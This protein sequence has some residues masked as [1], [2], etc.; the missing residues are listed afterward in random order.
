MEQALARQVLFCSAIVIIILLL[1]TTGQALPNADRQASPAQITS[2]PV[3]VGWGGARL[4]EAAL[5]SV[6]QQSNPPPSQVFSGEPA[7]NLE[8]LLSR[9]KNSGYSGVRVSFDPY[10]TDTNDTNYMSVYNETTARRAVEI[11][12]HFG[13]WV[14]FDHHGYSDIF[15]NTSCWL[16]YWK[17][18]V[19]DIGPLYSNIV[20]EPENEPT[21]NCTNSPTSCPSAPCTDDTTCLS[22]L[23]TAFQQWINQT[24]QL[25]D[26]H[27]IVVQ[28]L[29]SYSCGFTD[30]SQG[31]P[32]VTDS[33]G[34]P[35]RGGR[36]FIS[37]HSYMDYGVY[38][39]SWDNATAETVAHQF[40]QAVL[41][42]TANT[43]WPALNTEGGT[44]PLCFPCSNP[45]SD[46]VLGGSAGYTKTTF[47]FIQTLTKLYDQNTPQRTNWV[48][49]PAGSW[50][51]TT[52]SIYG[53]LD[54]SSS[55]E[56]WG[57]L[58]QTV[59]VSSGGSP[60]PPDLTSLVIWY[61]IPGLVAGG[62]LS[63]TVFWFRRR[64]GASRPSSSHPTAQHPP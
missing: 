12:Q 25:G 45:P 35:S 58:L 59:P 10:C 24:R 30:F 39:S 13:L 14:I 26:T 32:T 60:T 5:G 61:L 40:Y 53:A 41:S 62:L 28:N 29:C 20:W 46:T 33:L 21:L 37:L 63:Y 51:D 22:Y 6:N 50:T 55:P 52:T 49:W 4:D 31:Y 11:A 42:G 3:I 47:H 36:I 15:R 19:Q 54:C 18:I 23:S 8:L 7:T 56:G 27:W 38:S 43:G 64:R 2:S 48:W 16:N 57:C 34:L 1:P 17:P 9:L 44:D